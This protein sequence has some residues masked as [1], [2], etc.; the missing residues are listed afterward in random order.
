MFDKVEY[1]RTITADVFVNEMKDLA[2]EIDSIE[3]IA[4]ITVYMLKNF[5]PT[6]EFVKVNEIYDKGNDYECEFTDVNLCHYFAEFATHL[7]QDTADT[8]MSIGAIITHYL[9]V[10]NNSSHNINNKEVN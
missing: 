3:L 10:D 9:L 6:L 1:S 8:Y 7:P 5:F 2:I 4:A